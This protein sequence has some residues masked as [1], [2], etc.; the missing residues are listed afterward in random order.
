[1][2][3]ASAAIAPRYMSICCQGLRMLVVTVTVLVSVVVLVVSCTVFVRQ[4]DVHESTAA[5][6]VRTLFVRFRLWWR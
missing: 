1:M 2:A 4:V 3:M 5:V 6:A